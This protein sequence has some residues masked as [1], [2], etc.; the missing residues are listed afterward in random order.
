[1]DRKERIALL[2]EHFGNPR[3]KGVLEGAD[4]VMPGGSPECGGSVVVYLE[5]DGNG[6]I[7]GLAWTGQGDTISMG[8]TS[9]IVERVL[10]EELTMQEVLDLDY[11]AFVDGLGRDVIGS[12][13]RNATLGL[14]TLKSAVRKFQRDRL[15]DAEERATA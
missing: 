12:R 7:K 15:V 8:A 6:G 4:V 5:G 14:S 1:L 2:V 3:H 13:T 9:I 11:E 10:D